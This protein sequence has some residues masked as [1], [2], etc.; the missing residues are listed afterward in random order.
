MLYC[1]MMENGELSGPQTL[2]FAHGNISGFNNLPPEMLKDH[3]WFPYQEVMAPE[4]DSRTQ[5]VE[6]Q[7]MLEGDV[8]KRKFFVREKP[9]EQV[10]REKDQQMAMVRAKRNKMLSDCDWTQM[11]DSPLSA[12]QKADWAD[13]RQALRNVPSQED[14]FAI[15]W[16][17]APGM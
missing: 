3:G 4:F 17:T 5:F 10:Q 6:S 8:A 13:Y 11:S 9:A 14:P 15:V 7:M 2:P 12:Q 16:P 1:K